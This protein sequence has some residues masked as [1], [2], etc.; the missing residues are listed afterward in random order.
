MRAG[1]VVNKVG[2]DLGDNLSAILRMGTKAADGGVQLVLFPEAALTGLI[3]TDNPSHDLPLGQEI[4]GEAT[5]ALGE[6]ARKRCLWLAIGLLERDGNR[7]YDSA[8]LLSPSGDV[9]LKYRRNQPQWH[10]K[11]ADP[12]IY[13]QG[14]DIPKAETP[15]GNVA[16]L[17][18][19]DLFDDVIVA[20]VRALGPDFLLFPFTRC[21]SDGSYNQKRWDRE[22][23]PKYVNRVKMIG[24]LTLMAN[25]LASESLKED[26]SFGGAIA[27]SC[28]G[29]VIG[30]LPLGEEGI[31][32]VDF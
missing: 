31:L 28:D 2:A 13:C 10:G 7:L 15:L 22:E 6:L 19:G 20:K 27:V 11:E 32:F 16:I 1:L 3:N 30:S 29:T 26:D 8:V 23:L 12:A 9:A 25:Y 14:S 24:A 21:F 4:P 17:V 18:C 5:A